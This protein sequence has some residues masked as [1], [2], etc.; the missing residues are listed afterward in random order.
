MTAQQVNL[1]LIC[2][3]FFTR[4]NGCVKNTAPTLYYE[5]STLFIIQ[6]YTIHFVE[7]SP[8]HSSKKKVD[9]LWY[10]SSGYFIMRRVCYFAIIN[11]ITNLLIICDTTC[12]L[13]CVQYNSME[14]NAVALA[15]FF[16]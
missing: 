7:I 15:V 16:F 6:K 9:F 3:R 14:G 10:S 1:P 2:M 8:S 13:H 11:D 5:C 4:S 12:F